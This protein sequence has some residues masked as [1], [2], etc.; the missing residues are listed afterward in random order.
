MLF[1]GYIRPFVHVSTLSNINIAE[2][3]WW[4]AINFY[5]K[6]HWVGEKAVKGFRLDRIRTLVSMAT[7]NSHMVIMG[8][9]CYHV[10]SVALIGSFLSLACNKD[11]YKSSQSSKFAQIGTPK[12]ELG[13]LDRLEKSP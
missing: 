2:I 12:A 6:H 4:I 1:C 3:S 9:L 8:K 11:M 13:A 10:F 5:L 7:D